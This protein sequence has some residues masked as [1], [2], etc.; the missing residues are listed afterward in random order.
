MISAKSTK[1]ASLLARQIK[2]GLAQFVETIRSKLVRA[3]AHIEVAIDYAEDDIPADIT[4]QI[5]S[6]LIGLKDLLERTLKASEARSS[7]LLGYKIAIV[8]KPNVGKSSLLNRLV[9]YERAIVSSTAG[10]TRDTVEEQFYIGGVLIKLVD[11]AGIREACDEIEKIGIARSKK[12][13]DES[14]LI[15]AV[16][17]SSSEITTEDLMILDLIRSSEKKHIVVLN[18]SDLGFKVDTDI[19]TPSDLIKISAKNSIDD[20]LAWLEKAVASDEASEENL[21]VNTRQIE[22]VS[23][24]NFE[25]ALAHNTLLQGDLELFSYHCFEA[26]RQI[27][28]LTKPFVYDELLDAMFGEFCLG[29]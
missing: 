2:G 12:A 3:R 27:E 1:A 21:L 5:S 4:Q 18:K 20:L 13:I 16:F 11:T 24:A 19:F 28:T 29:K 26:I 17:D 8:G 10:T 14:D 9:N 7:E 23:K 15:L 25:I 22:A 6:D